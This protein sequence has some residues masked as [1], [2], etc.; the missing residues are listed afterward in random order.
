M[1][2]V[3]TA[4]VSILSVAALAALPPRAS[5]SVTNAAAVTEAKTYANAAGA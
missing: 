3:L 1:K 2:T 5:E 4:A